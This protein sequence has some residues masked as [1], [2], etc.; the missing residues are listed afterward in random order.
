MNKINTNN[1][2]FMLFYEKLF[3]C[4]FKGRFRR[5]KLV[6]QAEFRKYK[7]GVWSQR[8]MVW[9]EYKQF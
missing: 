6:L 5:K 9:I 4:D 3:L 7:L 1:L 8:V 2:A